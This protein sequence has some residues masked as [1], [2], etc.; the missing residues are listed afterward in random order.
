MA[1]DASTEDDLSS[2]GTSEIA[3]PR[4]LCN[5]LTKWQRWYSIIVHHREDINVRVTDEFTEFFVNNTIRPAPFPLNLSEVWHCGI[6]I[7]LILFV[8]DGVDEGRL[9][10][11]AYPY[12]NWGARVLGR[13]LLTLGAAV[14]STLSFEVLGS[15]LSQLFTTAT[16]RIED[17]V[18]TVLIRRW[19]WGEVDRN[20]E[21][22]R[23]GNGDFFWVQDAAY[24]R[25]AICETIQG[26]TIL[27]FDYIVTL[28]LE[29]SNHLIQPFIERILGPALYFFLS[30]PVDFI[31]NLFMWLFLPT[32]R[33]DNIRDPKEIWVEYGVPAVIQFWVVVFLWLLKILYQAKTERMVMDRWQTTD[34]KMALVW[35]LI[36]ATAMHLIAYTAYQLVCCV[37]VALRSGLPQGSWYTTIIDGSILPS[38]G[39]I[40]PNGRIFAATLLFFFHWILRAA[41]VRA[42][43]LARP[44]LMPYILWQTCYSIEG[45]EICWPVFVNQLADDMSL[46]DTNKRVTSRVAMTALFGLRS[47]WPAGFHLSNIVDDD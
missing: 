11:K 29:V 37:I 1:D 35:N 47:P 32:P 23:R 4:S 30:I 3:L 42:V 46:L 12:L 25:E 7:A 13:V 18:S 22:L 33:L 5:Y 41:S 24:P 21:P 14:L 28:F 6:L 8:H 45:A 9:F 40:I 20:G 17:W 31:P 27:V 44:F 34:P 15:I 36:R 26:L 19:H 2:T 10:K 43:R 38:L 16:T 39:R